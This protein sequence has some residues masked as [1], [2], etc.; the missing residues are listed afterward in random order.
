MIDEASIKEIQEIADQHIVEFGGL[1]PPSLIIDAFSR[2]E[3]ISVKRDFRIVGFLIHGSMKASETVIRYTAVHKHY[4]SQN[5]GSF[6]IDKL[7][8]K[9]REKNVGYIIASVREGLSANKFWQKMGFAFTHT[10]PSRRGKTTSF[11]S[12]I[13]YKFIW[14]GITSFQ[15]LLISD[16]RYQPMCFFN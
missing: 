14:R 11:I 5:I 3:I 15:S 6:L 16:F 7:I 2:D 9:A 8:Q 10:K 13:S 4:K 12:F 1:L